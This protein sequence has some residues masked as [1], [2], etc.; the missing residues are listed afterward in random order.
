MS[1]K[2]K[3]RAIDIVQEAT[4]QPP[5]PLPKRARAQQKEDSNKK[6]KANSD[7][8]ALPAGSLIVN[9]NGTVAPAPSHLV[10]RYARKYDIFVRSGGS[11]QKCQ[12]FLAHLDTSAEVF[13]NLETCLAEF[14]QVFQ[15]GHPAKNALI[16][17]K[18]VIHHQQQVNIDTD[19]LDIERGVMVPTTKFEV[20]PCLYKCPQGF[21]DG[22]D[23]CSCFTGDWS[24]AINNACLDMLQANRDISHCTLQQAIGHPQANYPRVVF[25]LSLNRY[26]YCPKLL[27]DYGICAQPLLGSSSK[28]CMEATH[29]AMYA[30]TLRLIS[31]AGNYPN[32]QEPGSN[33]PEISKQLVAGSDASQCVTNKGIMKILG[34][35]VKV[36][37]HSIFSINH[38][39]T[40]P[41]N[42][43]SGTFPTWNKRGGGGTANWILDP[44]KAPMR[45][46]DLKLLD[47]LVLT[48]IKATVGCLTGVDLSD[49]E[50]STAYEY[51]KNQDA[52]RAFGPWLARRSNYQ[53]A[54]LYQLSLA[55]AVVRLGAK[56]QYNPKGSIKFTT[57]KIVA[58]SEWVDAARL[59]NTPIHHFSDDNQHNLAIETDALLNVAL[60]DTEDVEMADAILETLPAD[61]VAMELDPPVLEDDPNG[62]PCQLVA[63]NQPVSAASFSQACTLFSELSLLAKLLGIGLS[64]VNKK[65]ISRSYKIQREGIHVVFQRAMDKLTELDKSPGTWHPGTVMYRIYPKDPD[66]A[67]PT[68]SISVSEVA[69][70]FKRRADKSKSISKLV[71]LFR[72][73]E[74]S[75]FSPSTT[76]PT[77]AQVKVQTIHSL[78]YK[79]HVYLRD[80]QRATTCCFDLGQESLSKLHTISKPLPTRTEMLD[81]KSKTWDAM[82]LRKWGL[83]RAIAAVAPQT[84][85][86]VDVP[87]NSF[88]GNTYRDNFNLLFKKLLKSHPSMAGI[89]TPSS[90]LLMGAL[91]SS[92]GRGHI[93]RARTS[94]ESI[95]KL[96]LEDLTVVNQRWLG[97]VYS[98]NIIPD[99]PPGNQS[100]L[101]MDFSLSS[102]VQEIPP[103]DTPNFHFKFQNHTVNG[104]EIQ[105]QD[106]VSA[107]KQ[108]NIQPLVLS[109]S[110]QGLYSFKFAPGYRGRHMAGKANPS[111]HGQAGAIPALWNQLENNPF[112]ALFDHID[113]LVQ[114]HGRVAEDEEVVSDG[115]KDGE[116]VIEEVAEDDVQDDTTR[117]ILKISKS[118]SKRKP[119]E[120]DGAAMVQ[121]D[122]A[123]LASFNHKVK[124]L[125]SDS[126]G[127]LVDTT[128]MEAALA[129]MIGSREKI[130]SGALEHKQKVLNSYSA[131]ANVMEGDAITMKFLIELATVIF[132]TGRV[133]V[134][135][136]SNLFTKIHSKAVSLNLPVLVND[137]QSLS[138]TESAVAI[139][140]FLQSDDFKRYSNPLED[141]NMLET[142]PALLLQIV[143]SLFNASKGSFISSLLLVVK[144]LHLLTLTKRSSWSKMMVLALILD[145]E[146]SCY[147][148]DLEEL[149]D[150]MTAGAVGWIRD[151]DGAN[152]NH[153]TP[154]RYYPLDQTPHGLA[155]LR[156]SIIDSLLLEGNGFTIPEKAALSAFW[157]SSKK[158]LPQFKKI[159]E[160]KFKEPDI[161][162]K[163]MD[164]SSDGVLLYRVRPRLPADLDIQDVRETNQKK[165]RLSTSESL[166]DQA[167]LA[168]KEKLLALKRLEEEAFSVLKSEAA[169]FLSDFLCPR[170]ADSNVPLSE[171]ETT[172]DASLEFIIETAPF[173]EV[174]GLKLGTEHPVTLDHL[175]P[176]EKAIYSYL[177]S[178]PP[179][180]SAKYRHNAIMTGALPNTSSDFV[181]RGLFEFLSGLA[182][183][184]VVSDAGSNDVAV[185]GVVH[186]EANADAEEGEGVRLGG[187]TDQQS[188]RTIEEQYSIQY[189]ELSQAGSVVFGK[190][191]RGW[192]TCKPESHCT[193]SSIFKLD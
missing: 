140:K 45:D 138:L 124:D 21:H 90:K 145:V 71:P 157:I 162:G 66:L 148:D 33:T 9:A 74:S 76:N 50:W 55:D 116:D 51:L 10:Q 192:E 137:Q 72:V 91:D 1:R 38:P 42:F 14:L 56:Q 141:T 58:S 183:S 12:D 53:T 25:M 23:Q 190:L 34:N 158:N 117:R 75:T 30:I 179:E 13:N 122:K 130:A 175:S 146:G 107:G 177:L 152:M 139:T 8:P 54:N 43:E 99:S 150:A 6:S 36:G 37:E 93:W 19:S 128:L 129:D 176:H 65:L 92:F 149:K 111:I 108:Q 178:V 161:A 180:A 181:A 17:I 168:R 5:P 82:S 188:Q 131:K 31:K 187:Y 125:P 153:Y 11:Q 182:V 114:G 63:D 96:D 44:P 189:H 48:Q 28:A 35:V 166:E 85:T 109:F 86:T 135:G 144:E 84:M 191:P 160:E 73:L 52:A 193:Y 32:Q 59:L 24:W 94:A 173:N 102:T 4:T 113:G 70:V 134:Q 67:N 16:Q 151:N 7:I 110:S 120:M 169:Q 22:I 143:K 133:L 115:V 81:P 156:E 164:G 87:L 61:P 100:T 46:R 83:D 41:H 132:D 69:V 29:Q 106:N 62:N 119:K 103:D 68:K 89:G 2:G 78:F 40:A 170:F 186:D 185:G 171:A 77:V 47:F 165:T 95:T 174:D 155:V 147:T 27:A 88:L 159:L 142:D 172:F 97:I 57:A 49:E 127:T 15:F 64:L 101:T 60:V 121:A 163:G 80:F 118:K 20:V 184:F 39:A 126:N 105:M 136:A 167:A 3:E 98:S 79:S 26:L 18:E 154:Y 112:A 104:L 123:Q